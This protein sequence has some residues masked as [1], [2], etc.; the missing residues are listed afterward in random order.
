[1]AIKKIGKYTVVAQLGN[2]A[3]STILQINRAEDGRHYALKVVPIDDADDKKFLEQAEHEFRVAQMLDHPNL[4]KIYALEKKTDWLFRVKQV[5]LLI[6]YVPGNTLDKMTSYSIPRLVRVFAQVAAGIVH[7]H[8]R[9]VFHADLKPGNILVNSRNHQP[10]IID[11]GLAHIRG[12]TKGG[13]IQGTPEYMAPE[14]AQG[15]VNERS[16]IYNFGATMYRMVTFQHPPPVVSG[17]T[18]RLGAKQYAQLLKPVRECN[19]AV[20]QVLADLI[21]HCLEFAPDKR[22]ERMSLI[23]GELDR[24]ADEYGIPDDE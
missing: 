16:D 14:S 3:H 21:H 11:F 12:E 15:V 7:M 6:E 19:P 20:P 17:G 23:Q 1:M 18:G 10:K 8:R 13:R 9:G 5:L 4:I 22:P 24:L 2:G